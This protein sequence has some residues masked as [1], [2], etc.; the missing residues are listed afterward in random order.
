ME[1]FEG[2]RL[3]SNLFSEDTHQ[4]TPLGQDFANYVTPLKTAY[5]DLD[6]Y[7]LKATPYWPLFAGDPALIQVDGQVRNRGN[8]A[9][10]PFDVRLKLG[11]STLLQTWNFTGLPRRHQPGFIA[12]F[13]ADY[14]APVTGNR[15]LRVVIDEANTVAEPCDSNNSL[16]TIV[17]PPGGTDLALSNLRTSPLF[18]PAVPPGATTTVPLRV[19]LANLGSIGTSAGQITVKFYLGNP[20][21]GGTLLNTQ[22]LTPGGVTLPAVIA[23]DW[24][25]QGPGYYDIYAR[26]ERAPEESNTANNNIHATVIVPASN[27]WLPLIKDRRWNNNG[28][29]MQLRSGGDAVLQNHAPDGVSVED[30]G[31]ADI[32]GSGS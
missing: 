23:Y 10:G 9:S 30:A 21:A 32:E 11:S 22:T 17:V 26:V 15:N 1:Y 18:L 5:A 19:D 24:P 3:M 6:T 31:G 12:P 16:L 27:G 28:A 7:T 20:S 29:Y 14:V 13:H 25:N 8:E 2:R 4:I